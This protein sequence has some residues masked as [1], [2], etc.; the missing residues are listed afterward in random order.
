MSPGSP[1]RIIWGFDEQQRRN[2][3]GYSRP[4]KGKGRG[5]K[6]LNRRGRLKGAIGPAIGADPGDIIAGQ[7][8]G[9]FHKTALAD[10]E[11]ART[12]PAELFAFSAA[13]ALKGPSGPFALSNLVGHQAKKTELSSGRNGQGISY[14]DRFVLI[15][16]V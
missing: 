14:P 7:A 12:D 5:N 13:M 10:L 4:G 8:P 16:F 11:P 2:G 1:W 15:Q 6:F 9:I 3:E